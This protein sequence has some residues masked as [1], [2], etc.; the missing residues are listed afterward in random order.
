ML[1]YGQI[2]ARLEVSCRSSEGEVGQE[3][4]WEM[5]RRALS[6]AWSWEDSDRSCWS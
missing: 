4:A 3:G 5:L 1:P 6:M 2:W